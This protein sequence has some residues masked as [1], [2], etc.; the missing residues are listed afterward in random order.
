M[1]LPNSSEKWR[2]DL[3]LRAQ[4][5]I[6]VYRLL[7][8]FIPRG[9]VGIFTAADLAMLLPLDLVC[10]LFEKNAMTHPLD[11]V[12]LFLSG[13]QDIAR[14]RDFFHLPH[15]AQAADVKQI[16]NAARSQ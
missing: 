14:I 8:G 1:L 13:F 4:G 10:G 6:R 11:C 16:L 7:F 12:S 15:D 9:V 3:G 5:E 2:A